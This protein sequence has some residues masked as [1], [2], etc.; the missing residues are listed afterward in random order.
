MNASNIRQKTSNWQECT[1]T[2]SIVS[3]L[4][5]LQRDF[6]MLS[7]QSHVMRSGLTASSET[8]ASS[9]SNCANWMSRFDDFMFEVTASKTV[10]GGPPAGDGV[11]M[12]KC[13]TF[14]SFFSTP[15]QD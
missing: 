9:A 7:P 4:A 1:Q 5:H 13:N 14:S 15:L 12:M 6:R 10:I 8:V 3:P 2:C 11:T